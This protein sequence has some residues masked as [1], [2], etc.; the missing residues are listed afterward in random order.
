MRFITFDNPMNIHSP[1]HNIQGGK[2]RSKQGLGDVNDL[3]KTLLIKPYNVIL[4][5][6]SL[7]D[8]PVKSNFL[9]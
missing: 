3:Q 9:S 4:T 8:L 7:A 5:C 2:G 1:S 6:T